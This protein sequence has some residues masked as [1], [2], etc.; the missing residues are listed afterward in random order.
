MS[1]HEPTRAP[2]VPPAPTFVDPRG[3]RFAAALTS[4]VLA[5]A[6]L[7]AP[8]GLA[9]GLLGFQLIVFAVGALVGP[10]ATPYALLFRT[11]LRPRLAPPA[12]IED[13]RPPRFA[14]GVGLAF[15]AVSLVG[16][17]AGLELVGAAAAGLAL[18]AAFLNAVFGLC[19][20]CEVY[21]LLR[22]AGGHRLVGYPEAAGAEGST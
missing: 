15:A 9:A 4:I 21:L 8:S 10:A 18:M 17:A 2:V 16:Y 22:R 14:Q 20:G 3:Q 1:V 7:T 13:A 6:L 19:L 5:L 11:L 12:E